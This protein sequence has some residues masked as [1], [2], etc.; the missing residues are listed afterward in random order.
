M[1]EMTIEYETVE[2]EKEVIYCDGCGTVC[3]D[4]HNIVSRYRCGGCHSDSEPTYTSVQNMR[5]RLAEMD[6]HDV[7]TID[8]IDI[9]ACVLIFPSFLIGGTI[10]L[11]DQI[12]FGVIAGFLGALL[13]I[14]MPIL[15]YFLVLT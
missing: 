4:D 10:H 6:E 8:Y 2:Q 14:V 9:L 7:P 12:D 5:E 13:W 15:Y 3:T 11:R 1:K